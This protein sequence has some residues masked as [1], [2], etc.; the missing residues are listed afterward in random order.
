MTNIFEKVKDQV[1]IAEAVSLF[2]LQLNSRDKCHCPF[3]R[4]K[5]PSFSIDRKNNIFT[6][7]GCGE[8]GDV[9]AFASKMKDVEPLEGAKFLAEAFHIDIEDCPKRQSIK[10]YLTQCIRD[11]GQTDYFS[12]RGLTAATIKTYCLGYDV[13]RYQYIKLKVWNLIQLK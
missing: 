8:S 13:T 1:K 5:T 7:F 12:R 10:E 9:I 6:C 2:G 4:E 3:H 11:V